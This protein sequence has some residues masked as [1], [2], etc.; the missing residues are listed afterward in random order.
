M[1]LK[2]DS[3]SLWVSIVLR[4]HTERN[5][6]KCTGVVLQGASSTS[7]VRSPNADW[8]KCCHEVG[9]KVVEMVD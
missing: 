6:V 8:L 2:S 5:D 7:S 9:D 1:S 4:L 3:W